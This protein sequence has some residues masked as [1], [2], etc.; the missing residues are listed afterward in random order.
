MNTQQLTNIER[1]AWLIEADGA[2]A[3]NAEIAEVVSLAQQRGLRSSV[4]DVLGDS[5]APEAL[6]ERAFGYVAVRLASTA[7]TFAYAA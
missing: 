2:A 6:R 3:H 4:V 1:L 5:H 7:N